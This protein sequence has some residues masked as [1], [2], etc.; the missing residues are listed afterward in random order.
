M[1]DAGKRAVEGTVLVLAGLPLWRFA[2]G[3]DTPVITLSRA[4]LV[5]AVIGGVTLLHSAWLAVRGSG[6]VRRP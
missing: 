4:G 1:S 6:A 2:D 5:L 3:V